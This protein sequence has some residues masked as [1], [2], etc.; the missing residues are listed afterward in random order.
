MPLLRGPINARPPAG[1]APRS[2]GRRRKRAGL[3]LLLRNP[4]FFLIFAV[5]VSQKFCRATAIVTMVHDINKAKAILKI[6]K[7]EY[8]ITTEKE[9]DE[10]IKKQGFIDVTP[11]VAPPPSTSQ[12]PSHSEQ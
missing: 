9:L 4:L 7:E 11:F 12:P 2:G 8:G 6:L 1:A 5:R 10:A 3:E